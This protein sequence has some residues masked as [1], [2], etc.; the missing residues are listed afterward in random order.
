MILGVK[1]CKK[2]EDLTIKKTKNIQKANER[3]KMNNFG[4]RKIKVCRKD[5]DL[6]I[7]EQRRK[8]KVD[9]EQLKPSP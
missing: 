5:E 7:M 4:K 2:D 3:K 9:A 1:V 6:M 8:E